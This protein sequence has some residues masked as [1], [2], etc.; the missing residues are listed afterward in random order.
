MDDAAII[1]RGKKGGLYLR[2]RV[3]L[4]F[5]SIEP[6]SIIWISLK[7]DSMAVA[8]PKATAVWAEMLAAW[9]SRLGGQ[10]A[11]A[12]ERFEA[13]RSLAAARGVRYLPAEAVAAL[14]VGELLDRV[15]A[16]L[17]AKGVPDEIEALALL[18]GAG[19][20]PL[21]VTGALDLFRSLEADRTVGMSEDQRRIWRNPR[22]KAVRNFVKVAGDKP[23]REITRSDMLAFRS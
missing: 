15:T 13:A 12:Q 22:L 2:R 16:S 7:T 1:P 9:E 3:P 14:P 18:G 20:S 5:S 17:D 21:T 23:L 4:R 11:V 19:D 6:R 8:R 10:S